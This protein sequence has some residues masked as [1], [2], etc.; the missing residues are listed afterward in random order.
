MLA[1]REIRV[2][3]GQ[4]Q[5]LLFTT[6]STDNTDES[7]RLHTGS[8][9]PEGINVFDLLYRVRPDF[10]TASGRYSSHPVIGP[11]RFVTKAGCFDRPEIEHGLSTFDRPSHA[12]TFKAILDER[13]D[14]LRQRRED[15]KVVKSHDG[16]KSRSLVSYAPLPEA[17]GFVTSKCMTACA[18]FASP[19]V[20]LPD[21]SARF[22]GYLAA[23]RT[24][25]SQTGLPRLKPR[26]TG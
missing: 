22:T 21:W 10:R 19:P 17:A 25:G 23:T 8:S 9:I 1:S 3:R 26:F 14:K 12:G 5:D 6:D 20:G 4:K 7:K 2:I 16:C 11:L 24:L 13:P 15:E 18:A